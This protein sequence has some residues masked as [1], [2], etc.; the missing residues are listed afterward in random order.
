MTRLQENVGGFLSRWSRRKLDENNSEG[1]GESQVVTDDL[2]ESKQ[3][4]ADES[5][6]P[7]WQQPDVDPDIKKQALKSIFRHSE[8]NNLDGLNDYDEDY[9]VFSKLGNVITEEM[10]RMLRLAEVKK[11]NDAQLPRH[12]EIIQVNE[13]VTNQSLDENNSDEDNK[14]A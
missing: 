5:S 13:Q 4:E 8:F 9:T 14:L 7:A 3:I 6:L 11:Q 12:E 2:V 10:R 1:K